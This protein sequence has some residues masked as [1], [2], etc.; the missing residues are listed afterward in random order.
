[1]GS[2]RD[3]ARQVRE[4]MDSLPLLPRVP[5]SVYLRPR[6]SERVALVHRTADWRR[7][8]ET[9]FSCQANF[10]MRAIGK[11]GVLGLISQVDLLFYRYTEAISLFRTQQDSIWNA[12]ALEGQ[13]TVDMLEAWS[14]GDSLV[15]RITFPSLR[16]SLIFSSAYFSWRQCS[17]RSM[18]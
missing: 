1:M 18:G 7:L 11:H 15:C 12:S 9:F 16:R 8:S 13:C 2:P 6:K 10:L 14:L 4:R 3:R 17:R 5:C